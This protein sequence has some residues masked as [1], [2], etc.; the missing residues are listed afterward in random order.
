MAL[1]WEPWQLALLEPGAGRPAIL[2]R[3]APVAG[4]PIRLWAGAV[5][6]LEIPPDAIETEEGAVYQS[7]GLLTDI[8][9][10]DLHING[11]AGRYSFGIS[12][13]G[14]TAEVASLA[15][16]EAADVRN[17]RVNLGLHYFDTQWQRGTPVL[18]LQEFYADNVVVERDDA[19]RTIGLSVATIMSGRRRPTHSVWTDRDQQRR[20][21][22]DKFFD[23]VRRYF[24]GVTKPW[25]I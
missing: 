23:Q 8:P 11:D 17:A 16:L 4:D 13:A 15:T 14:V 6:D 5:R 22:G 25:P 7:M 2:L 24:E 20:S 10:I 9:P 3:I 19:S 12:G 18:W 21:P 1:D